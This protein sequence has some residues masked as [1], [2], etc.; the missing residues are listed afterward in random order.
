MCSNHEVPTTVLEVRVRGS[1]V[2]WVNIDGS[3]A[4]Y[5]RP[6]DIVTDYEP[7]EVAL[8]PEVQEMKAAARPADGSIVFS[9]GKCYCL[10]AY[11]FLRN[12]DDER[13]GLH[14]VLGP[15]DCFTYCATCLSL[16]KAIPGRGSTLRQL[17][18]S[19]RSP[20]SRAYSVP[21]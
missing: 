11:H 21:G 3:I 20:F 5:Y 1:T 10:K 12:V 19:D 15:T 6:G 13:P 17:F 16:D 2:P 8:P 9:N 18:L 4:S 14:L 7:A